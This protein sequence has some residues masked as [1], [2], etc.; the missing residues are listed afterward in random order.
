M[1]KVL[2]DIG[3]QVAVPQGGF[4]VVANWTALGLY[5]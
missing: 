4:F 2:N 1:V 3:M 5:D